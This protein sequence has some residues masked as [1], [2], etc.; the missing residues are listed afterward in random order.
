MGMIRTKAFQATGK[1]DLAK[2]IESQMNEWLLREKGRISEFI[3][4]TQSQSSQKMMTSSRE[5]ETELV[6]VVVYEE[7][8]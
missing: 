1:D 5:Q 4:I 3:S 2:I 6:V 7:K 8:S